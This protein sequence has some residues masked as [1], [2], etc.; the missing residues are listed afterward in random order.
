M[1][2]SNLL[3]FILII[4]VAQHYLKPWSARYR[5]T[6][7]SSFP[8]KTDTMGTAPVFRLSLGTVPSDRE[9]SYTRTTKKRKGNQGKPLDVR[10]IE[11]LILT[12]GYG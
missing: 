12:R 9:L 1:L 11:V 2:Q 10:L 5:G 4:K 3:I 7:Q 8:I 6:I